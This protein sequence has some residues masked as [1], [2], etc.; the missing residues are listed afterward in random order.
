[1]MD[2][3]EAYRAVMRQVRGGSDRSED[4]RRFLAECIRRAPEQALHGKNRAGVSAWD[5]LHAGGEAELIALAER[6]T[7]GQEGSAVL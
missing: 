5:A 3:Q 2:S 1:M 4:T 6:R 7:H